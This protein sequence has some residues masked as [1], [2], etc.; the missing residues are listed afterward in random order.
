MALLSSTSLSLTSLSLL[1]VSCHDISLAMPFHSCQ[2]ISK[3]D[4]QHKSWL[5]LASTNQKSGS[6][7]GLGH[8]CLCPSLTCLCSPVPEPQSRSQFDVRQKFC[9]LGSAYQIL[10]FGR[11]PCHSFLGPRL[12]STIMHC[13]SN[14]PTSF[15]DIETYPVIS[16]AALFEFTLSSLKFWSRCFDMLQWRCCDY[17]IFVI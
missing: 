11:R 4:V 14:S 13:T 10:R 6:R 7:V 1:I 2:F 9:C 15:R 17:T 8:S 16:K 3:C 5:G 12:R